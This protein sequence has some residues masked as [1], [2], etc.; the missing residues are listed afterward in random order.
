MSFL[1][2]FRATHS[3]VSGPAPPSSDS[4]GTRSA[5]FGTCTRGQGLSK[6]SGTVQLWP[7]QACTDP[8]VS[9]VLGGLLDPKQGSANHSFWRW[10][11]HWGGREGGG[12]KRRGEGR[13]PTGAW[14]NEEWNRFS[15]H[16]CRSLVLGITFTHGSFPLPTSL[17][18]ILPQMSRWQHPSGGIK[19][20]AHGGPAEIWDFLCC[21]PKGCALTSRD[22]DGTNPR[23]SNLMGPFSLPSARRKTAS[24]FWEKVLRTPR[25]R[26]WCRLAGS[27][28]AHCLQG[29]AAFC[30]WRDGWAGAYGHD[31]IKLLQSHGSRG[32][33]WKQQVPVVQKHPS[34]WW[35][36]IPQKQRAGTR[37]KKK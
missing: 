24:T 14:G 27:Y 20:P 26:G 9:A 32:P 30:W 2:L 3:P 18:N 10:P 25:R 6:G 34:S 36:I 37:K 7:A 33:S 23:K 5:G 29:R 12:G 28:L 13:F 19:H 11:T 15:A 1:L 16:I 8:L 4:G 35:I 17:I 21:W 31:H 22:S